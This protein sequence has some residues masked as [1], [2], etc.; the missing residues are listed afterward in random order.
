MNVYRNILHYKDS[1]S[2]KVYVLDINVINNQHVVSATWGRT[3]APFLSSQ[4]KGSF[5]R[6]ADATTAVLKYGSAKEKSGYKPAATKLK[7]PGLKSL[8]L[9]LIDVVKSN[10]AT[11]KKPDTLEIIDTSKSFRNIKL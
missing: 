2:D 6:L 8:G 5:P 4:I 7:I 3:D 9:T 1:N 11:T 10:I